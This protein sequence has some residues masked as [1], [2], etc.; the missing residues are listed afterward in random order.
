[1]LIEMEKH[2]SPFDVISMSNTDKELRP[3]ELKGENMYY[4]VDNSPELRN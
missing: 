4:A 2:T 3:Y 1:M